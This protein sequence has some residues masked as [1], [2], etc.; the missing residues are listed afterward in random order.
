MRDSDVTAFTVMVNRIAAVF[1]RRADTEEFKA[2]IGSYFR[3]L[4]R[5]ELA[6]LERAADA[7]ISQQTQFPKPAEWAGLIVRAERPC[8]PLTDAHARDYRRAEGLGFEDVPCACSAC[9]EAEVHEKPLRFVPEVNQ[10]GSDRRVK[11]PLTNR[12]VVA[13]H[14]AHGWELFRWYDARADF[15]NRCL[16]LGLR[17]NVLNPRVQP[18]WKRTRA[19]DLQKA[20]T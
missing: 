7:W 13:G 20:G 8:E 14:W 5:Y 11:D 4:R 2:L 10:D 6:D 16:E 3:V 12:I 15:Y 19:A 17:G 9:V 18:V 1:R